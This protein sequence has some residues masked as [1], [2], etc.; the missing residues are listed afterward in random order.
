MS[1]RAD[2]EPG[3]K[4]QASECSLYSQTVDR[5]SFQKWNQGRAER[6]GAAL[7][8]N[9]NLSVAF[10]DTGLCIHEGPAV[11]PGKGV[12]WISLT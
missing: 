5:Q 6:N 2:R 10:A 3:A 4:L 8:S 11:S 12:Y 7:T 1:K 9:P